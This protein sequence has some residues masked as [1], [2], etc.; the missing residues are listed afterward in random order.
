MAELIK[1]LTITVNT[2]KGTISIGKLEEKFKDTT[3]AAQAL[4]KQI[5]KNT[6]TFGRTENV[7]KKE[8]QLRTQLRAA[9]A[10]GNAEYQR[11]SRR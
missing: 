2:D 5:N 7:I 3:K 10:G 6:G 1:T 4:E 8:I 11:Q 9:T